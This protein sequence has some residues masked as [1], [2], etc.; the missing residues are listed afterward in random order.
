MTD[1]SL[2]FT[3]R[4]LVWKPTSIISGLT[5]NGIKGNN[6]GTK[7]DDLDNENKIKMLQLYTIILYTSNNKRKLERT[8]TWKTFKHK[9]WTHLLIS[10]WINKKQTVERALEMRLRWPNRFCPPNCFQEMVTWL[11][12]IVSRLLLHDYE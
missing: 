1:I 5:S 8:I 4:I 11:L 9:N 6:F 2:C 3:F 7:N 10:E 12:F